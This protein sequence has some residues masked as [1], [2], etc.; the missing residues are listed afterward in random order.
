[1]GSFIGLCFLGVLGSWCL[2]SWFLGFWF[3]G[4]KDYWFLGLLVSKILVCLV[5]KFQRLTNCPFH[6]LLIDIDAMAK[7]L[8]ILLDGPSRLAGP[9]L[10]QH[11]DFVG[12]SKHWDVQNNIF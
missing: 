4:F 6:V 9:R 7:I 10:F 12:F 1:M 11:S 5:S 2:V 3:L 8:K